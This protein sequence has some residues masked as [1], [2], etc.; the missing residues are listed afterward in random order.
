MLFYLYSEA[1]VVLLWS[2]R[3]ILGLQWVY[4]TH[5]SML[6]LILEWQTLPAGSSP[7][8]GDCCFPGARS[9]MSFA[10]CFYILARQVRIGSSI[11]VHCTGNKTEV[12]KTGRWLSPHI[13]RGRSGVPQSE[14]VLTL[15]SINPQCLGLCFLWY[16]WGAIDLL[17]FYYK[18]YQK[19]LIASTLNSCVLLLPFQSFFM[20]S[21]TVGGGGTGMGPRKPGFFPDMAS[22]K[23]RAE[24]SQSLRLLF[25]HLWRGCIKVPSLPERHIYKEGACLL[26]GVFQ[27]LCDSGSVQIKWFS[28]DIFA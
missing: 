10:F 14:G 12:K 22:A 4:P 20:P 28:A 19:L 6:L 7:P 13:Q 23:L 24:E 27:Y 1:C 18:H 8:H 16:Q 9:S 15:C 17:F 3:V 21:K 25:P 11:D 26:W 5:L 2:I